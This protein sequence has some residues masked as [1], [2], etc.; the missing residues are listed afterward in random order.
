M[1][2]FSLPKMSLVLSTYKQYKIIDACLNNLR[3]QS[4]KPHEIIITNDNIEPELNELVDRYSTDFNIILLQNEDKGFRK[5]MCL[6]NAVKHGT[7]DVFIFNDGDCLPHSRFVEMHAKLSEKNRVLC[8]RRV[9]LGDYFIEPLIQQKISIKEIEDL[10][11][12]HI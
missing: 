12:I 9:M 8:G 1:N 4:L 7:G 3:N 11:L 10:S 2:K 5:C 6:N